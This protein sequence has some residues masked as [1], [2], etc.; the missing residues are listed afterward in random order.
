MIQTGHQ[1]RVILALEDGHF[2]P[3]PVKTGQEFG[4]WIEVTNGLTVN[5][6]VVVS[7]QFLIDSEASLKGSLARLHSH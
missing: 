4:D 3:H 7:G 1:Q 6:E 5:D 2:L